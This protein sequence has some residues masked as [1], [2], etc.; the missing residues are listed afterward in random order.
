MPEDPLFS[1]GQA[2]ILHNLGVQSAMR[3]A[4]VADMSITPLLQLL[5]WQYF[6]LLDA[7]RCILG[8][9]F[10]DAPFLQVSADTRVLL[11]RR[12]RPLSELSLLEWSVIIA[13][14]HSLFTSWPDNFFS[15]L[16][17]FPHV[18]SETRRKRDRERSTGLHR[19]FGVLYEWWLYKRLAHPAFAFLREAF[20]T[21]LSRHYV[22]GEVTNRLIPFRGRSREQ[23]PGRHYLTKR[24]ARAML[25]IGEDVLQVLIGKGVLRTLKKPVGSGEKK[26]MFLIDKESVEVLRRKWEDLIPL[27]MVAQ[28]YLGVTRSVV[29]ALEDARLLNPARGPNTDGYN[30]RLYRRTEIEQFEKKLLQRSVKV[31]GQSVESIILPRVSSRIGLPLVTLVKEVLDGNLTLIEVKVDHPLFQRLAL[32]STE[33]A[34]F[35]EEYKRRQRVKLGLLTPKEVAFDLGIGVKVL[36]RWGQ[37]KLIDGEKLSIDGQKPALF[38]RRESV[39]LFRRT[40]AFTEEVAGLLG[41]TAGTVGRLVR[42]GMLHPIMGRRSREHGTRLVFRRDEVEVLISS[43]RSSVPRV[44]G[45]F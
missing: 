26:N 32:P 3:D 37:W 14:V 23:V 10:P 39:E 18:R 20:E 24:Q 4:E 1:I 15:F 25:G 44:T 42:R 40:Y 8:P 22:G 35:L 5:P 36:I 30:Q 7:F 28:S 38:F 17:A 29:L 27:E 19:D 6:L 9:L 21:Y 2:L 41:I 31:P 43:K 12:P 16:D 33:I 11:R 13:T 34:C 45:P